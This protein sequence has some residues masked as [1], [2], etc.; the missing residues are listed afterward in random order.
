MSPEQCYQLSLTPASDLFSVGAVAYEFLSLECAS[1]AGSSAFQIMMDLPTH[2]PKQVD[3]IVH[4]AQGAPPSEFTVPIMKAL[5]REP[6]ER[7]ESAEEFLKSLQAAV[8]GYIESACPRTH[9]KGNLLKL[10]RWL[11]LNPFVHVP[12]FYL[13]LLAFT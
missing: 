13:T 10:T 1:P 8:N 4:P 7:Q 6:K 11:D 3:Y 9:I 5:S 12:I 2:T